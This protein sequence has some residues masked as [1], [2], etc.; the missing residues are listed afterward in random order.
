MRAGAARCNG[1]QVYA[2]CCYAD[3]DE[4]LALLRVVQEEGCVYAN[5]PRNE[6]DRVVTDGLVRMR[7]GAR[8]SIVSDAAGTD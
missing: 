3:N 7:E 8:V 1:P 6:G 5:H 4:I 2:P